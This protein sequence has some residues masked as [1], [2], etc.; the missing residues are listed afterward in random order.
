MEV[1]ECSPEDFEFYSQADIF[2]HPET[3]IEYEAMSGIMTTKTSNSMVYN[4][5]VVFEM[6]EEGTDRVKFY[7]LFK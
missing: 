4:P 7:K 1:Y 2:K 5:A 3:W 6:R